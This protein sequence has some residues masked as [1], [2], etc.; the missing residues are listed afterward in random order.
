MVA[1]APPFKR[2][3]HSGACAPDCLTHPERPGSVRSLAGA[4]TV[5]REP[6][7]FLA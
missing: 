4:R 2:G 7:I 1:A 3:R 6:P 5:P